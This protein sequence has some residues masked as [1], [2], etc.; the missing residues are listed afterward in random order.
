M[1]AWTL[2]PCLAALRSEFDA[3][4]PGRDR[5]ADGAIGDSAHTSAS[6]HT[7]DEDSDV[8]RARDSDHANEVHALDIDS[9]GPWPAG[10]TF[11]SMVLDIVAEE[12][13]KWLDPADRC[14]LNYVIFDRKI[15]DKDNN[16]EPRDYAGADPHTNHAHFSARYETSC[17]TDTRPWGVDDMALSADDK[18]WLTGEIARL[19]DARAD[20]I[21]VEVL[22]DLRYDWSVDAPGQYQRNTA[23]LLG[24]TW[25]LAVR[26]TT[27]G[28]DAIPAAGAYGRILSAVADVRAALAAHGTSATGL[29]PEVVD[30]LADRLAQALAERLAS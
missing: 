20:R 10:R 25:S 9:T 19:V 26:G 23:D 12:R 27:R 6:D 28:G 11:K 7:P 13:A 30:A 22:G 5:G 8:L 29:T 15:Y 1:S 3:I 17:E 4:A 18:K 21:P 24:D 16:F 2:I 14:R